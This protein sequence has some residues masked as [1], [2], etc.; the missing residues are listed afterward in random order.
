MLVELNDNKNPQ[1]AVN[2]LPE[3]TIV[4]KI[5]PSSL[6]EVIKDITKKYPERFE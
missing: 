6:A 3:E 4:E 5:E 1:D 2:K